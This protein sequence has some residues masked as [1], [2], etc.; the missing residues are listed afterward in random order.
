MHCG[1]DAT[2]DLSGRDR[3]VLPA[4]RLSGVS[5][6]ELLAVSGVGRGK[7]QRAV[8]VD[9]VQAVEAVVERTGPAGAWHTEARRRDRWVD[10]E[11]VLEPTTRRLQ[12]STTR[13]R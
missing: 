6:V 10:P 9:E 8:P 3:R 12:I 2:R 7:S 11:Q 5:A 13:Y 4:R 1:G